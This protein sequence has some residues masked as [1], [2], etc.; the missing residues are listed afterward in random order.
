MIDKVSEALIQAVN[1]GALVAK[2][3]TQNGG[4]VT[5][6]SNNHESYL[7]KDDWIILFIVYRV[8]S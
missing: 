8:P 4:W 7:R 6:M 1:T 2:M 5:L 3:F